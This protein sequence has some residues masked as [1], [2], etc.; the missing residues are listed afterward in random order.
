MSVKGLS[1]LLAVALLLTT[2]S[3]EAK[4]IGELNIQELKLPGRVL[5]LQT[6]DM[7]ADGLEDL[8][9]AH[10]KGD[11]ERGKD[12]R[13]KRFISI[14]LQRKNPKLRW[15]AMPSYTTEVPSDA[16]LF[17]AGDFHSAFE[18]GE[19]ALISYTGIKLLGGRRFIQEINYETH[20]RGF[21]DFPADGGLF[22]WS[23]APDL[24]GDGKKGIL[25]PTKE[26]YLVYGPHPEKG[27]AYRGK[28]KVPSTERFGPDLETKFLNRFLTYFS[29]L[30]RVVALDMNND[31]RVDLVTYRSKGLATFTQKDDGTFAEEPDKVT[32]LKVVK[33]AAKK[34]K[35]GDGKKDGFENVQLALKD[36]NRDGRIDIV[37]TKTI[38]KIGVFESLRTQVLIFLATKNGIQSDKPNRIINL[39]GVTLFP[40][41][42]DFNGDDDVDIVLSSL[43]MDM[44]TNVKRAILKSVSTT[45]SIYL[46]TGGKKVYSE[47]PSFETD[48]DVDLE[49]VEKQGRVRLS[50]FKGDLNGDGLKDMLTV[51]A[52]ETLSVVP[53]VVKESFFGGKE[54]TLDEDQGGKVTVRTSPNLILKDI[55]KDGKDEIIFVYRKKIK[56]DKKKKVDPR[57]IIR[58]VEEGQ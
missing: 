33:E 58:I 49:L 26:G 5:D 13:I 23:L 19:I 7:N 15:I 37:A 55:D 44:L 4:S 8:V 42:T 51:S 34:S 46:F 27:L 2:N 1:L 12:G 6:T 50:F 41:F 32:P 30:P 16:V 17:V 22:L 25:F 57:S 29:R 18:G 11:S 28:V 43:R 14:F 56:G 40:E 36:L 54:M 21:F 45:Y 20:V 31:K 10:I 48:V 38:G 9:V 35:G 39:K 24:K 53:T 47:D 52:R 3:V